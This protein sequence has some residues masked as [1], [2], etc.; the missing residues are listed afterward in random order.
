MTEPAETIP[1]KPPF[2]ERHPILAGVTDQDFPGTIGVSLGRYGDFQEYPG[3]IQ[4]AFSLAFEYADSP[5]E[6]FVIYPDAIEDPAANGAAKVYL[7]NY[8]EG[9]LGLRLRDFQRDQIRVKWIGQ[10]EKLSNRAHESLGEIE[11]QTGPNTGI[12]LFIVV[13]SSRATVRPD[14]LI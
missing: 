2:R 6:N 12:N 9:N 1:V 3:V 13:D 5:A 8:L 4:R 11:R 14:V 7:T 10:K